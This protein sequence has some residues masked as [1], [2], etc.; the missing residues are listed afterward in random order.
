MD[1]IVG[2]HQINLAKQDIGFQYGVKKVLMC[3][4]NR[5]MYKSSFLA[6][7]SNTKY[8]LSC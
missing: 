5:M 2:L 3:I 7:V 8:G 4:Q 6:Y 1:N